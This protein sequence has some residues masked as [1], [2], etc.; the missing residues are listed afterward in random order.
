[1]RLSGLPRTQPLA[2]RLVWDAPLRL[3]HWLLVGVIAASW[4]TAKAGF[5]WRPLHMTLGYV[6][7]GLLFFRVAWG[8]V[9]TRHARFSSFVG[10]PSRILRY[11]RSMS[12]RAALITTPGHNPL[13]ALMVILMLILLLVQT[14][15]GLFTSDDIAYAGPYNEVVSDSLAKSLGHV[16]HINFNLILGAVALHVLAILFYGA[17][18]KQR[19][20]RAMLT[21]RKSAAM[22]QPQDA[23]ES[24]E[25]IKAFFVAL[26]SALLVY[27]L[28]HAAPAPK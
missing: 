22:I 3:F 13:G 6:T 23:I 26:L 4:A 2:T 25:F 10:G 20:I 7:I 24:S 27:W 9:G 19:L 5:D 21:G 14:G 1:V 16:H 11:V 15:S 8:V 12:S 17:V 18:K 28:V